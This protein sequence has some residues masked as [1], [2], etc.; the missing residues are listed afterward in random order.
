VINV[1]AILYKRYYYESNAIRMNQ[2]RVMVL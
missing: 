2:I 1:S